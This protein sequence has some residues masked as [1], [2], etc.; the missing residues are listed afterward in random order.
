MLVPPVCERAGYLLVDETA[1]S[2]EIGYLGR[3]REWE[4]EGV[5]LAR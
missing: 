1:R 4:P 3:H 2:D 5:G